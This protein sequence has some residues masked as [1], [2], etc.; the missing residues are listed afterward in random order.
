MAQRGDPN[1]VEKVHKVTSFNL[2]I[3]HTVQCIKLH[4]SS[5][6][7]FLSRQVQARNCRAENWNFPFFWCKCTNCFFLWVSLRPFKTLSFSLEV[8]HGN[9]T[10]GAKIDRRPGLMKQSLINISPL[11]RKFKTVSRQHN[12]YC[13]KSGMRSIF[14]QTNKKMSRMW[15]P[16]MILLIH[17]FKLTRQGQWITAATKECCQFFNRRRQFASVV[18]ADRWC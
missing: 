12:R 18:D 5:T 15:L 1:G 11:L 13:R 8:A 16:L 2:G 3:M 4:E 10:L 14:W 6:L 7:S 9:L 17:Q